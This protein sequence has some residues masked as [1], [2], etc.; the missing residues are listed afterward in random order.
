MAVIASANLYP[1][2]LFQVQ[3][4]YIWKSHFTKPPSGDSNPSHSS[5]F[6]KLQNWRIDQFGQPQS[7]A[8][9][10]PSQSVPATSSSQVQITPTPPTVT[11]S[12]QPTASTPPTQPVQTTSPPPVSTIPDIQPTLPP[13]P[14]IPSPSFHDTEGPSFETFYHNSPPTLTYT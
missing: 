9:P 2:L 8:D 12:V 6:L 10:T 5:L 4:F 1:S 11:H 14:Q 3:V 13:S 7:S